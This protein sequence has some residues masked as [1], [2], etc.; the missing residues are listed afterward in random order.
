MKLQLIRNAT[1]LLDYANK[2]ILIDPD[3]GIKESRSSFTGKSKN[4]MVDLPMP[5]EQILQGVE[6]VIVSHLHQDH[7]DGIAHE[8]IPKHLPL[9][10]QPENESFIRDKGFLNVQVIQDFVEWEGIRIRR[11]EGHHG[12]GEV[13]SIMGKV[14]GFVFQ[15]EGEPTIYWAGDT[16]LTDEVRQAIK[17]FQPDF[18]IPHSCGASW[19]I[20]SGERVLIVMDDKQTLELC[21]MSPNSRVIATHM[22]ALDHAT[23]SRAALRSAAESAGISAEQLLIPQDGE[24]ISL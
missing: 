24:T 1:L 11:T 7:F 12:L 18:I 4:P 8:I 14:S 20:S 13:E 23:I 2:H 6:L 9:F 21:Q 3:F 10:C 5:I 15:A 17:D 19:P 22:E 16:V